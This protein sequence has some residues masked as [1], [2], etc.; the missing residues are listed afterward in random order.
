M[1]LNYLSYCARTEKEIRDYLK[2]KEIRKDI[3]EEVIKKLKYYNYIND[4]NYLNT[5]VELNKLNNKYSKKRVFYT[6]KNKGISEELLANLEDLISPED[7]EE[8]CEKHFK[9]VEKRT[10][11]LPYKKRVNKIS[12][13]LLRRGFE[14]SLVQH[15]THKIEKNDFV[16]EEEFNKHFNHYLKLYSRKKIDKKEAKNKL[17]KAMLN[18]GYSYE[19]IT[20]ALEEISDN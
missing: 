11:G 15:F 4:E 9:L 14:Y 20:T 19:M 3:R 18:R 8:F 7:E 13:Y 16:E 12:N 2:K 10:E 1:C 17:I 5:Y 6:L